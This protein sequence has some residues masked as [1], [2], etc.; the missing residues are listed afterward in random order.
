MDILRRQLAHHEPVSS[1]RV[2]PSTAV[3]SDRRQL[4]GIRGLRIHVEQV[5]AKQK[6]GGNKTIAHRQLI[7]AQ[8]QKRGGPGDG[9]ANGW[10][11]IAA[12]EPGRRAGLRCG[13]LA[14]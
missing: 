14:L 11:G 3:E 2:P 1:N 5:L 10:R 4:P 13:R 6:Y 12:D 7:A 9:A 8:L